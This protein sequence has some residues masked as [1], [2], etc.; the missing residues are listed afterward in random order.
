MK[1][2]KDLGKP[3]ITGIAT[4]L[5]LVGVMLKITIDF[6]LLLFIGATL[7][8][9]GGIVN[10]KTTR[11]KPLVA[12]IITSFFLTLFVVLVLSE[13]PRLKYFIPLYFGACLLGMYS[14]TLRWKTA[15]I[16]VFLVVMMLF[17]ALKVI[18]EDLSKDL[19]QEKFEKL[20][21]IEFT[22]LSG[23]RITSEVLEGKVLVLDFFGTWCK[24]CIK[25]L[26]VLD[27]VQKEFEGDKDVVFYV[28]NADVQD[29]PERFDAFIKSHDYNYEYAY[30]HGSKLYR[31]LN[32]QRSGLPSLL[33]VDKDQNIRMMHVG[34]NTAETGF[35]EN[36]TQVIRELQ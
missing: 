23:E 31:L 11:N 24:P 17:L 14:R 26:I 22:T 18:P 29:T 3:V 21:P 7:F 5:I 35:F 13:L 36:M 30:D 12:L 8:F 20:P 34:Y 4:T 1:N 16:G 15:F 6:Q 28:I 10:S 32:L 2:I 19:T 33:I 27:K 25:E 9:L